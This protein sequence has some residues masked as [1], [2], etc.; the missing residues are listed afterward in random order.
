MFDAACDNTAAGANTE[1][2]SPAPFT[3]AGLLP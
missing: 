2:D 3:N 1:V